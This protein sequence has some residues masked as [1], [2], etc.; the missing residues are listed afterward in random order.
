MNKSYTQ[1]KCYKC[2]IDIMVI[3][4]DVSER[5]YCYGCA[6]SKLSVYD[7]RTGSE[8]MATL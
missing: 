3:S 2:D 5:Y 8:G 1:R 7:N 6:M 4:H